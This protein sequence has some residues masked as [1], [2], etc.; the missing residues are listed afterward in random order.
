MPNVLDANGLTVKTQTELVDEYSAALEGIYGADINLDQDSPDGQLIYDFIQAVLD[1]EDLLVQIYNSFD[2]DL[3]VGVVLDQRVAI[4]GIQRKGGTFTVTNITVTTSQACTLY[5][6]DQEAQAVYTVSDAAGNLWKLQSTQSPSSDG[7]FIYAFQSATPGANLTIPNTIQTPI[8]IV[9]GVISV[10]N[11][12]TYTSLGIN[13]ETDA[14]LRLRR[15]KSVSIPSIGYYESLLAALENI[16]GV[17]FAYIEENVTGS[18]NADG[19]PGHSIWVILAGTGADADIANAIYIYRNA[20]CGMY[21]S[22]DA[23]AKSYNIIQRD[24]TTFTVYWDTV[25]ETSIFA[26]FSVASINKVD[27]PNIAAIITYLSENFL[28][29]VAATVNVNEL[30]TLVQIADPNTL[31]TSPGFSTAAGGSY[32][33]TLTPSAKNRQF[34]FPAANVIVIPI[35]M[36]G[37]G[38]AYTFDANGVVTGTTISVDNTTGTVDF[39]AIGGYGAY[40]YT[41]HT[42]ASGGA[43]N[44]STGVYTAGATPGTDVVRVTDSQSRIADCTVTVV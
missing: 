23:G 7:V 28:P 5:G 35:I 40:T 6:L 4:N 41:M 21:D 32:T 20:G 38:V 25:I 22:M 34:N 44:A 42:N 37:P 10:N 16:D 33:N 31:V 2:P 24:G 29:G 18:T 30:A 15:Q 17:T 13:E 26:K 12:T 43:V 39:A 1:N 3:A 9:L 8:T 19:V 11:P 36:Y 27:P 14:Q